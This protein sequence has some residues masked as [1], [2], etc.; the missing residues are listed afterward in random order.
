IAEAAIRKFW[1]DHQ[2]N[3]RVIS[4]TEILQRCL[5]PMINEAFRLLEENIVI[6]AS[7]IDVVMVNGYG[8]PK[9][10]GGLMYYADSIGLPVVLE[11]M[12][13]LHAQF[14]ESMQPAKLLRAMAASGAKVHQGF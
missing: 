8:W 1:A 6:R 2:L 11:V 4:D 9:H 12:E 13:K 10:R 3:T 5:F 7:D 14:G